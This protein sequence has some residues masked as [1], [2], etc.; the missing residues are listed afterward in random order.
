MVQFQQVGATRLFS[1]EVLQPSQRDP[2]SAF[3]FDS[4][5]TIPHYFP[6]I[7]RSSFHQGMVD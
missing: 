4:R 1:Q 6:T 5:C 3:A 7:I 2:F